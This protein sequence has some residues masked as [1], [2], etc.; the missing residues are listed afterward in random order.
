MKDTKTFTTIS[1]DILAKG[2][3]HTHDMQ[4]MTEYYS[5]IPMGGCR[6]SSHPQEAFP[7]VLECLP[8]NNSTVNK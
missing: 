6:N 2:F 7:D 4:K 5:K 1:A 3:L 8:A